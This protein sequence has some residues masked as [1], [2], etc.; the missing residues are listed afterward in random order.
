MALDDRNDPW[1]CRVFPT[2][3]TGAA[4]EWFRNKPHKSTPDYVT[5]CTMFLTQYC[6]NKKQKK[7]IAS[8]SP[9]QVENMIARGELTDYLMTKEHA[10]PHE[11]YPCKVEGTQVKVIHAIHDRSEDDQESDEVYRSRLRV[12]HKFR[13]ISLVNAINPG[14]ISIGFGDGNLSRVQLPDEDPLVISLLVAKCMI[15]RVLVDPGS[16]ANIITK[17]VFDQLEISSSSIRP[18]SSP[19]MGFDGT[20]VNPLG[21]IDLSVTTAKRTLKENFV[22]TEIHHSYNLIMGRGW[23]HRMKGVSSTLH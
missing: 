17:T 16:S 12:T 11:I 23:I 13:K 3:L 9:R 8:S 18:N 21:V 6:G 2:S 14:S 7:S 15:R 20:R 5:L 4:L 1:M 19:L 10:K 22:L